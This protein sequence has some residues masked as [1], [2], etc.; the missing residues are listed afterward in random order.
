[1]STSSTRTV[2][3]VGLGADRDDL[4]LKLRVNPVPVAQC[5]FSAVAESLTNLKGTAPIF[6][7]YL[8]ACVAMTEEK[9]LRGLI[10]QVEAF[11]RVRR[12]S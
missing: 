1:M 2:I 12:T 7:S 6:V 5:Y 3:L 8:P 9:A 11:L 4:V 10:E